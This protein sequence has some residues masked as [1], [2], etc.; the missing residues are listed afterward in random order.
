MYSIEVLEQPGGPALSQDDNEDRTVQFEELILRPAEGPVDVADLTTWLD[1]RPFAFRA[2]TG[3]EGWHLGATASWAERRRLQRVAEPRRWPSGIRVGVERDHV[4]LAARATSDEL[5]RALEFVLHATRRG[6]WSVS[7]DGRAPE[8]LGDPRRLFPANLPAPETL[9]EDPTVGPLTEGSRVVFLDTRAMEPRTLTI[10]SSGTLRYETVTRVL[11]A[12][13]T[14][15]ARTHWNDAVAEIV[16]DAFDSEDLHGEA[17]VE[18]DDGSGPEFIRLDPES[19]P[20]PCRSLVNLARTW[21][22]ALDRWQPG[23]A[24]AGLAAMSLRQT[25]SGSQT[26]WPPA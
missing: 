9:D 13:L 21:M 15:D 12:Q 19:P 5:S 1:T 14:F 3:A 11:T 24:V 23:V 18:I 17:V 2:P 16:F 4:W 26:P 20:K 7:V 10:H 6:H 8:P 25:T 22:A